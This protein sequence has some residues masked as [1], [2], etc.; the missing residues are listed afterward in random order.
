M[1]ILDTTIVGTN[2]QTIRKIVISSVATTTS[3]DI[4][5]EI[6]GLS[7]KMI[8]KLKVTL[9]IKARIK[10]LYC[11]LLVT[12]RG[13]DAS[14]TSGRLFTVSPRLIPLGWVHCTRMGKIT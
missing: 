11:L 1:V 14:V 6:V 7:K 13:N 2:K 9:F 12:P 4:K 5:L 3:L 10:K 8:R